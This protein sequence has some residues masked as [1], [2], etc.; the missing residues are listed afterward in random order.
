MISNRRDKFEI[1]QTFHH[2]LRTLTFKNAS[3]CSHSNGETLLGKEN[4]NAESIAI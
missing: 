3:R 1:W 2:C 4:K